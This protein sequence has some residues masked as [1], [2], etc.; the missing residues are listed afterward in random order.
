[1]SIKTGDIILCLS[2]TAT[3]QIIRILN[4]EEFNHIGIAILFDKNGKISL[5]NVGKLYILEINT[6][7][8]TDV[9][10]G[11]KCIGA[12][13]SDFD[14]FK[15]RYNL[16]SVRRLHDRYRIPA[17][18]RRI[19]K[20]VEKYRGY[21]F[22]T[23]FSDIFSMA[24]GFPLDGTVKK[25][26]QMLCSELT[27]HFLMECVGTLLPRVDKIGFHGSINELLGDEGPHFPSLTMPG[28]YSYYTTPNAKIFQDKPEDVIYV[29]EA[30]VG[31]V[32]ISILII[33]LFLAVLL[34]IFLSNIRNDVADNDIK[35]KIQLEK[36][37]PMNPS[38]S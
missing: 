21:E 15:K 13:Y 1:M 32:L 20:F 35:E 11:Q 18:A 2:N 34:A 19:T 38:H 6:W 4:K 29:K 3:A 12:A 37:L 14:W 30:N 36:C 10:T 23:N 8:R 26:K 27:A 17:L 9:I 33:V 28:H 25:N 24:T 5:T 16:L 7:E 22:T 31:A